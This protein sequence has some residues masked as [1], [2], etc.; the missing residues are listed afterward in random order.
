MLIALALGHIS[1]QDRNLPLIVEIAAL[2]S[3]GSCLMINE[4]MPA[5]RIATCSRSAPSARRHPGAVLSRF[6][7]LGGYSTAVLS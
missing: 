6:G 7:A 2:R 3:V 5:V 4:D 1:A